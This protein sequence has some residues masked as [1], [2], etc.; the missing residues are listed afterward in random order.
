MTRKLKALGLAL[1]AVSAVSMVTASA[2]S[3]QTGIFTSDGPATLKGVNKA[4]SAESANSI[5]SFGLSVVCP[6]ATYT[7]HKAEVTPHEKVPNSSSSVTIT[8][9]YGSCAAEGGGIKATVDM[10]GCDFMIHLT[11]TTGVADQY[12]ITT[13]IKCPTGKHIV[14][15][16]FTNAT[17]HAENKAFCHVT[18]TEKA[19]YEGLTQTDNTNNTFSLSGTIENVEAD[20][21]AIAGTTGDSGILCPKE[22][23]K[24]GILHVD[25]TISETSGTSI[26]LSH[27]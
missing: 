27:L 8:P 5:T 6:N 3:A 2:A 7:G 11:K 21:E 9:N 4:G 26:K 20:K 17:Q 23:T 19:S 13:T 10:N 1:V 25:L 15:T 22:T 16:L 18:I 24:A 12:A 14:V